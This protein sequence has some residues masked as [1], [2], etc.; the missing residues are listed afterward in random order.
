MR[1]EK[2]I[3]PGGLALVEWPHDVAAVVLA[4]R[5]TRTSV[6]DARRA[7]VVLP[8]A[9]WLPP[10]RRS[11]RMA[12]RARNVTGNDGALHTAL[13][14]RVGEVCQAASLPV[15]FHSRGDHRKADM[16]NSR[17][18]AE[19]KPLSLKLLHAAR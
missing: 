7:L 14:R 8:H 19:L 6:L 10:P 15:G 3:N 13:L 5:A 12:G 16:L 2:I 1:V 4:P 11:V 17:L 9:C 18:A